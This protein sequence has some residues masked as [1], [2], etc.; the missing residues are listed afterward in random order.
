MARSRSICFAWKRHGAHH[1]VF[2]LGN[3]LIT[4]PR[5]NEINEMTARGILREAMASIEGGRP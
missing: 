3:V 4:I 1:D 5:H 2:A